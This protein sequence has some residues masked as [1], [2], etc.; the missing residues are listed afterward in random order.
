MQYRFIERKKLSEA[1]FAAIKALVERCNVAEAIE[2]KFNWD[3]MQNRDGEHVSDILAYDGDAL[4]GC[5]PIDGF[6]QFAEIILAVDPSYRRRGI[7]RGL[8]ERARLLSQKRRVQQLLLVSVNGARQGQYFIDKLKL[9]YAFSEY[10]MRLQ[11]RPEPAPLAAGFVLRPATSADVA[12]L[13]RIF[14]ECFGDKEGAQDY[15][16]R[17]MSETG[18][19]INIALLDEQAIGQIGVSRSDQGAYIRGVAVQP[20]NQGHGY[21][22]A[23]L[24]S[25]VLRLLDE[26]ETR[27]DL[28]VETQNNNALGLYERCGFQQVNGFHYY[29]VVSGRSSNV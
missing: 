1:E 3:M 12:D 23:M 9:P 22:R 24:A 14:A 27:Q 7:G 18:S 4:V 8:Y 13:V 25:T 28:D 21:G 15:V 17:S 26:G 16:Q 2:L 19:S 5:V 11:G 6:G 10:R 29:S 20:A